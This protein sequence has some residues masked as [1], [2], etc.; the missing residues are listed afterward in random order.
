V[1]GGADIRWSQPI[2]GF[3]KWQQ[4]ASLDGLSGQKGIIE[5]PSGGIL[6]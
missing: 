6:V 2:A 1:P 3:C 4:V 5:A